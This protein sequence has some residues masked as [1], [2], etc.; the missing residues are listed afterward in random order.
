M[1]WIY[2]VVIF[3][4]ILN[5]IIKAQKKQKEAAI[6]EE[7][8][9]VIRNFKR[10]LEGNSSSD[11]QPEQDLGRKVRATDQT[12]VSN[13]EVAYPTSFRQIGSFNTATPENKY[14]VFQERPVIENTFDQEEFDIEP[15]RRAE[16]VQKETADQNFQFV[17]GLST[18][19]HFR[20]GKGMTTALGDMSNMPKGMSDMKSVNF[21]VYHQKANVK[22]VIPKDVAALKK[23]FVISEIFG[24][25]K[26]LRKS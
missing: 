26:A 16:V 6:K 3:F 8:A 5:A 9:E 10:R 23:Y 22:R 7:N 25:P 4:W 19:S 14:N 13:S 20:T 11:F 2:F 17:S 12:S 21:S 24:K 15:A 18:G 1:G